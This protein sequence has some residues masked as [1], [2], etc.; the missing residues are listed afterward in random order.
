MHDKHKAKVR[1]QC[2][3]LRVRLLPCRRNADPALNAS[4]S[5]ST[6]GRGYDAVGGDYGNLHLERFRGYLAGFYTYPVA[7]QCRKQ[8]RN[9]TFIRV[10]DPFVQFGITMNLKG[11]CSNTF[12]GS[13]R[14]VQKCHEGMRV[15]AIENPSK[16]A[17]YY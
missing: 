10:G 17:M 7:P 15:S 16:E 14:R 4:N 12:I 2:K 6:V 5:A 9:V 8:T 11:F 13:L 3:H 1:L